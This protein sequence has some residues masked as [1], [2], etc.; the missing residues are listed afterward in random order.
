MKYCKPININLAGIEQLILDGQCKLQSGQY[1]QIG[2]PSLGKDGKPLYSVFD[3]AE[4]GYIRAYHG[5]TTKAAR[6]KY[7]SAK[8]SL[9]AK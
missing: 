5:D 2:A 8:T 7:K 4:K 9:R 6:A 1:I 3:Y